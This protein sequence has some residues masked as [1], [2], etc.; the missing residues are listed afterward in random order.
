VVGGVVVVRSLCA[1]VRS[2]ELL[3]GKGG[4]GRCLPP[5]EFDRSRLDDNVRDKKDP[6]DLL[7]VGVSCCDL[8]RPTEN[9]VHYRTNYK[10]KI[11]RKLT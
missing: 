5:T 1:R 10:N 9:H 2:G 11:N 6:D 4:E 3:L 7:A 8:L